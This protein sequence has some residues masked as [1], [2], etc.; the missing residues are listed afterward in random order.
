MQD[1][2]LSQIKQLYNQFSTCTVTKVRSP[3]PGYTRLQMWEPSM[4]DI[5]DVRDA[6]I[7]P[8]LHAPKVIS[9]LIKSMEQAEAEVENLKEQLEY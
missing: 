9:D 7:E 1:S 2:H 3:T 8:Y 5:G 4:M 6:W